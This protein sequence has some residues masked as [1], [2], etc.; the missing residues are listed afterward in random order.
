MPMIPTPDLSSPI[1]SITARYGLGARPDVAARSLGDPNCISKTSSK[2][3][4]RKTY[5]AECKY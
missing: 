1:R 3:K 4:Q 2:A 5:P